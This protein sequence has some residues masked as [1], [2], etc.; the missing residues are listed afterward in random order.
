MNET[1]VIE[2]IYGMGRTVLLLAGPLLM[3]GLAAGLLISIVQV[4]TSIQDPT[5]SFVP[6]I[7]VVMLAGLLLVGWMMERMI[8]Y[9]TELYSQLPLFAQ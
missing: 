5:L 2:L 3:I 4:V 9:T 1:T 6:R 7:V 8:T